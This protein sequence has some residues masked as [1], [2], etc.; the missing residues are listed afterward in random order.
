MG[1]VIMVSGIYFI[2]LSL[3]P[4]S[5]GYSCT[6]E[7]DARKTLR[8]EQHRPVCALPLSGVQPH[9]PSSKEGSLGGPLRIGFGWL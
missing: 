7:D 9:P 1:T 8:V 6:E 2:F 5:L 3:D 4:Y